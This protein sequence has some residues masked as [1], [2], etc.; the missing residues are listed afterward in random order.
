[1]EKCPVEEAPSPEWAALDAA[2]GDELLPSG[3]R[4]ESLV[5]DSPRTGGMGRPVTGS[6]PSKSL[7]S[8]GV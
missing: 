3:F 8:N 4:M 7:P 2:E 1:M 5:E 6:L